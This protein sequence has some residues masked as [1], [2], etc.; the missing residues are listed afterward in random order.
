MKLENLNRKVSMEWYRWGR[1]YTEWGVKAPH[2]EVCV[3]PM[4]DRPRMRPHIKLRNDGFAYNSVTHELFR[5]DLRML[6]LLKECNDRNSTSDLEMKYG[7]MALETVYDS[8]L[9]Y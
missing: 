9:I 6:E 4:S 8:G 2:E 7:G 5:I 1:G 3:Q